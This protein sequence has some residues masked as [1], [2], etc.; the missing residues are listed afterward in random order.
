MGIHLIGGSEHRRWFV[1]KRWGVL[2]V[3][4][5]GRWRQKR[6]KTRKSEWTVLKDKSNRTVWEMSWRSDLQG[7][8]GV[9]SF[10]QQLPN[11]LQWALVTALH[12]I[13]H[14]LHEGALLLRKQKTHMYNFILKLMLNIYVCAVSFTANNSLCLMK[15]TW[16]QTQHCSLL[17][18]QVKD[19]GDSTV[20]WGY[21]TTAGT[22]ILVSVEGKIYR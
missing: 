18:L 13:H 8:Y 1:L 22:E 7:F 11:L 2:C 4:V 15:K 12:F 10:P 14:S 19:G 16:A 3:P 5:E 9:A 17:T 20:L 6:A 21:L